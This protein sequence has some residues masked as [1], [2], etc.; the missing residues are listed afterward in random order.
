MKFLFGLIAIATTFVLEIPAAFCDSQIEWEVKQPFRFFKYRSD[1]EI[2]RWAYEFLKAQ[3]PNV[4][5]SV[6]DIE[7]LLSDPDWWS[8]PL[9]INITKRFQQ[10]ST[11]TAKDLL[12]ALRAEEINNE[13]RPPGYLEL[14]RNLGQYRRF[15]REYD[16]TRLGWAS[17]L[18]PAHQQQTLASAEDPALIDP[19]RVAVCWNRDEQRHSNCPGYISP[20]THAVLLHLKSMETGTAPPAACTWHLDP[21]SG[22]SFAAPNT[23]TAATAS[24][25]QEIEV[26]IPA[27]NKAI[28]SVEPSGQPSVSTTIDQVKDLLVVGLGDSFSSGEG[29]PDVPA[30]MK[31]TNLIDQ[32]PLVNPRDQLASEPSYIPLR[33]TDGDYFAAQWID[34]ACH[35][36]AYSYQM[37]AALQLALRNPQR[38]VTFL[39]YACSGAEI[40]QGLFNPFMGP[41]KVKR[42]LK[43]YQQAQL[44]L[45][46]SELCTDGHYDGSAVR[47]KPLSPQQE[48]ALIKSGHYVFSNSGGAAADS[49]YRCISSPLGQGFKRPVDILFISIGGNDAGFGRWIAAALSPR[50]IWKLVNAYLPVLPSDK[51]ACKADAFSCNLMTPQWKRVPA[52]YALLRD[53]LD[54]RL[55]YSSQAHKPILVYAYPIS[56]RDQVGADC[57]SGNSGMTVWANKSICLQKNRVAG[58]PLAYIEHFAKTQ[59]SMLVSNFASPTSNPYTLV[60]DYVDEFSNHGFCATTAPNEPQDHC[61]FF[62]ELDSFVVADKFPDY[63]RSPR[64]ADETLHIPRLSQDNWLPFDPVLGFYPYRTRTRWTRTAN[65]VYIL[66]NQNK[67]VTSMQTEQ[68]LLDLTQSAASGSFHPTAEAH[69]R[70]ASSFADAA[71]K[72]LSSF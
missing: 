41:E 11:I 42:G 3:K 12:T 54:N 33:K 21:G 24:C 8:K 19:K 63:Q 27:A 49:A 44:S 50:W 36:S 13:R 20:Q 48:D 16:F 10:A 2:H 1:F 39:G 31:W 40:N 70:A 30:K 71:E 25:D 6:L 66:I 29:N 53:F 72:M 61:Y 46:L 5:P 22:A 28:I 57:H 17:L 60:N 45:L 9:P 14:E 56:A 35:R 7:H 26:D 34:R 38:A 18:F 65:D 64:N 23:G 15:R 47:L 59:L 4:E 58:G 52:R 37:R 51:T 62:S 67:S 43:P 32:D 68:V 69:A 55:P